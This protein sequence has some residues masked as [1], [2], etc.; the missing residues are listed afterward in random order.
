MTEC[1]ICI[2][3]FNKSTRKSIK[4]PDCQ[5]EICLT[6]TKTFFK[7][8]E[9]SSPCCAGCNK[10]FTDD[11]M[12]E[13]FPKTYINNDLKKILE[14]VLFEEE[15][16]LLPATQELAKY[17]MH[18]RTVEAQL[19]TDEVGVQALQEQLYN[20][21][22]TIATKRAQVILWRKNMEM[23]NTN[24]TNKKEEDKNNN[25]WIKHCPDNNCNG[26]LSTKWKCEMC[27]IKVCR[28]CHEPKNEDH[29][30]NPDNIAT[31]LELMKSAKSCPGCG[32]NIIKQNGCNQMWCTHCKTAFDWTTRKIVDK[33]IHNP[34]YYEWMRNNSGN[35]I[36]QR[37]IGD[38]ICGGLPD[39]RMLS[40]FIKKIPESQDVDNAKESLFLFNRLILHVNLV[41]LIRPIEDV[42]NNAD[43]R[44]KYLHKE[45][46]LEKLKQMC[47]TRKSK[48]RNKK[49]KQLIFQTLRD[50]GTDIMQ[51]F[52][53]KHLTL[54][55]S[56]KQMNNLI[57][58]INCA[59]ENLS[60]KYSCTT[61]NIVKR[62]VLKKYAFQQDLL[63]FV[64][65]SVKY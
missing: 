37:E 16:Q 15:K 62:L 35:G 63:E 25:T 26:Y 58:Y 48:N 17:E 41:E 39:A 14:N 45:I 55:E 49:N 33:N 6:C 5:F 34:H 1:N 31:A 54:Q 51:N 44:I 50:A 19:A 7:N 30:C 21:R 27:N 52:V 3:S 18:I 28:E 61:H 47:L 64:I 13:K 53:S 36:I 8:S 12:R 23:T 4:C 57:E 24:E 9:K 22:R 2:E 32:T 46:N 65:E 20:L 60:R 59:F 11:F 29:Q 10:I 40:E 42:V 56:H 38:V 43:L